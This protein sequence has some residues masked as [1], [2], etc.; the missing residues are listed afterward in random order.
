MAVWIHSL[1]N[2]YLAILL[3]IYSYNYILVITQS[4][5]HRCP[6]GNCNYVGW[7][8]LQFNLTQTWYSC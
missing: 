5:E 8:L 7:Y 6:Y 2:L 1:Y 4:H 3:E